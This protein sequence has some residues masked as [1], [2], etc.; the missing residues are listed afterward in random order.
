[1]PGVQVDCDTTTAVLDLLRSDKSFIFLPQ[2]HSQPE[3]GHSYFNYYNIIVDFQLPQQ[4]L[5]D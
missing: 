3:L 1:M 4:L 2:P 5:Y